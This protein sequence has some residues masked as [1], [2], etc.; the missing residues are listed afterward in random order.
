MAR[1]GLN[2]R[3]KRLLATYIALNGENY[4][5]YADWARGQG[6]PL[7]TPAYLH[8]WVN[9]NRP[10]IRLERGVIYERLR[11]KSQLDRESRLA[12]LEE[13]VLRLDHLLRDADADLS[14][15]LIEQKRKC[16][17]AIAEER[18]E[19]RSKDENRASDEV[20]DLILGRMEQA[21]L[22]QKSVALLGEAIEGEVVSEESTSIG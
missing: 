10:E 17:Q 7:F 8:R 14:I 22:E 3:Q 5:R 2:E 6:I 16:L 13:D 1:K 11:M 4:Q 12:H 9:K 19:W 15:K 18:G 20:R 21:L